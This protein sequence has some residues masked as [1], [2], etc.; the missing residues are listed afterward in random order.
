MYGGSVLDPVV[1]F[2]KL[3]DGNRFEKKI[4]NYLRD[5]L[6]EIA[7]ENITCRHFNLKNV[8]V[9]EK[10][11]HAFFADISILITGDLS[12]DEI[13][14]LTE[15]EDRFEGTFKENQEKYLKDKAAYENSFARMDDI[16][17]LLTGYGRFIFFDAYASSNVRS[18][19]SQEFNPLIDANQNKISQIK[20]GHFYQSFAEGYGR[21]LDLVKQVKVG[22]WKEDWAYG[23]M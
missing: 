20:E 3:T 11:D 12:H 10:K 17:H 6:E 4:P 22:Y 13:Q 8:F 21:V 18:D 15:I 9:H 5:D 2:G 1:N 19:G 14:L 7:A 23:K 16:A